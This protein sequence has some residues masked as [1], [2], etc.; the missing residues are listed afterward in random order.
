M[1][2]KKTLTS[3]YYVIN[4]CS[5]LGSRYYNPRESVWLSV[6][7]PLIN[8]TYMD[9]I[10]N[11]GVSNSSNL[12]GY[13]YCYQNPILLTDPDGN[14]T[15][16]RD[17]YNT[18]F[19]YYVSGTSW[20][21]VSHTSVGY[22]GKY[23]NSQNTTVL[24]AA[25]SGSSKHRETRIGTDDVNSRYSGV[26]EARTIKQYLDEGS[27]VERYHY[28]F[29]D[30]VMEALA[31]ILEGENRNEGTVLQ[32]QWCTS[33]AWQAMFYAAGAH[34]EDDETTAPEAYK[35][36]SKVIYYS[37]PENL[38][39][40]EVLETGSAKYDIFSKE[41]DKYY[42]TTRTFHPQSVG[43]N[44]FERHILGK[45]GWSETKTEVNLNVKNL[46]Q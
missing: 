7:P 21:D 43:K 8:G 32:G 1:Q 6:D 46:N 31:G 20:I 27:T 14:Q 37:T 13:S 36:A 5:Y 35:F 34:P 15:V 45:D 44:W 19:V 22:Y 23:D 11:G 40:N 2:I 18:A 42:K 4:A 12:N 39:D 10:H 16:S 17:I 26:S 41:G 38:S 25:L 9:G 30:E 24:Y 3:E 29:K 28:K 33:Q